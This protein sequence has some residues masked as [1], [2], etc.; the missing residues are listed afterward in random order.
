LSGVLASPVG[1]GASLLETLFPRRP[2]VSPF[3]ALRQAEA[4]CDRDVG[5][6]ARRPDIARA[7][8]GFRAGL[9]AATSAEAA[10]RDPRVLEVVLTANGLGDQVGRAAL[11][12]KALLS[13]PS[14]QA[15]LIHRLSDARWKPVAETFDFARRG[16]DVIRQPAV[17]DKLADAYA[18]VRWRKSL[19]E[20]T[21]GLSNALTFRARAKDVTSALQILGDPVLREVV[22]KA[23]GIP[24]RI[25]FQ[26]LEAQQNAITSRLRIERLGD[27]K[28]VEAFTQRYL[29]AKQASAAAATAPDLIALAARRP[30]LVV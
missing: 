30:G 9:A 14:D 4:N 29:L 8:A 17:M 6:T 23:L 10:L 25:A 18:E 24:D 5:L 1:E 12:R 11:A 16:L 27:P 26:P 13:D 20:T 22:T 2:R 19:D 15:A 3:V 21:P 28:F 7:I